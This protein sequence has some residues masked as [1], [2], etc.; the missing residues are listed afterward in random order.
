MKCSY[1]A[2]VTWYDTNIDE[3]IISYYAFSSTTLSEVAASL[4]K[5]FGDCIHKIEFQNLCYELLEI[6]AD[7][8]ETLLKGDWE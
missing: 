4:E 3:D 6:P 5:Q 2:K 7:M 1:L 8:Y